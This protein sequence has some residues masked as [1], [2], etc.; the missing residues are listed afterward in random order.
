MPPS[1]RVVWLVVSLLGSV[2]AGS[3]GAEGAAVVRAMDAGAAD[4]LALGQAQSAAF[5]AL[6]DRVAGRRAVVHVATGETRV[7]ATTGA[8][9]F[10]GVSHG[11]TFVRIALDPRLRLDERTS[12]LAHEL[13]HAAELLEARVQSQAD[14]RRLYERIGR[15]VPGTCDAFETTA[16]AEAG[17]RVWRDLRRGPSVRSRL[18]AQAEGD[19]RR[20]REGRPR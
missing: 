20:G 18:A 19:A 2:G 16:A 5:R 11:W 9:Q 1:V 6:V 4:A 10:A 7:F 13:Q 17:V 12:V 3:A 8:T 15:A 14:V